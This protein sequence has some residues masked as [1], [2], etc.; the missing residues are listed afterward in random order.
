[1]HA[2]AFGPPLPP[3]ASTAVPLGDAA[4]GGHARRVTDEQVVRA[5]VRAAV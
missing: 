4:G 3:L 2:S 1:V 5:L